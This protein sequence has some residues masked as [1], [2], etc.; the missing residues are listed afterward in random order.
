ML[1]PASRKTVGT[2]RYARGTETQ[3]KAKPRKAKNLN[4][5]NRISKDN[6]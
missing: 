3:R 6:R 4:R 1:T 5:M 2:T